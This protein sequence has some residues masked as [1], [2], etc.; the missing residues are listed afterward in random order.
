MEMTWVSDFSMSC[1]QRRLGI[2][3]DK[4]EMITYDL[5]IRL[6]RRRVGLDVFEFPSWVINDICNSERAVYAVKS[7]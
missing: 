6:S 1:K 3:Q 5:C 4:G 2:Q 7:T